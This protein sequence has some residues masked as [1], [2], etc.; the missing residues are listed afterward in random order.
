MADNVVKMAPSD[1]PMVPAIDLSIVQSLPG[2]RQ[3]QV[4]TCF[5]QSTPQREVDKIMDSLFR[6]GDRQKAKYDLASLHDTLEDHEKNLGRALE[7]V[8]RL[9]VEHE[10]AKDLRRGELSN[11]QIAREQAYQDGVAKHTASGRHAAYQPAGAKKNELEAFDKQAGAMRAAQEKAD[12]ER[13]VAKGQLEI[14]IARFRE[15]I[16]RIKA[17]MAICHTVLGVVSG[18]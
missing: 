11:L 4:K 18:D 15:E 16:A 8:A 7:D 17:Q 14:S 9:D 12:N 5:L 6:A 10:A 1:E 13:T 3:I 2:D